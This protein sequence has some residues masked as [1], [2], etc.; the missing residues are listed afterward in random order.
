M[1]GEAEYNVQRVWERNRIALFDIM[2]RVSEA[3]ADLL[4]ERG[5]L[6]ITH[7]EETQD[8]GD[9]AWKSLVRFKGRKTIE[10]QIIFRPD[11]HDGT[12]ARALFEALDLRDKNRRTLIQ[13]S[14]FPTFVS[15]QKRLRESIEEWAQ[16]P[17][18]SKPLWER[19]AE[20]I[21]KGLAG[22][23]AGP[24]DWFPGMPK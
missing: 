2:A 19:M 22:Y 16:D 6:E 17:D 12:R 4:D 21:V 10:F 5:P 13:S 18:F 23:E 1:E 3:L 8:D 24:K 14:S 9:P 20:E 7:P 15:D 11:W